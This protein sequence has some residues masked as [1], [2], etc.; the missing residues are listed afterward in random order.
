MVDT[1]TLLVTVVATVVGSGFGT[2]I[3]GALLSRRFNTQLETHKALL[4]RSGKIH[5]RQVDAL[6][7]IHSKLEEASFYLQRAAGAGKLQGEVSDAELLNR[8]ALAMGAASSEFAKSRL[9]ISESLGQKLDEFFSKMFS[10]GMTVN[11]ALDP[12]V[13]NSN[14]RAKL[15][16][17][18][19]EIAYKEVPS[20]LK[21]ISVEAREVIHG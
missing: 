8:M 18:A 9:L 4:Q 10:G 14:A 20:V 6:L 11:L 15:V 21:A 2:A 13:Q 19:R 5:E 16:D 3:V 12:I 17:Q 1:T 7:L